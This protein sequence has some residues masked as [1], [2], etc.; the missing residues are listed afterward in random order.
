MSKFLKK[1]MSTIIYFY[2][3]LLIIFSLN[4]LF[5]SKNLLLSHSGDKHQKFVSKK[6]VPLMGGIFLT[7]LIILFFFDVRF[8]KIILIF[9]LV[10][11]LDFLAVFFFFLAITYL[12]KN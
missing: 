3:V 6:S 10:L 7:F 12:N 2:I 11:R 9:F 1:K 5:I 8:T 4:K